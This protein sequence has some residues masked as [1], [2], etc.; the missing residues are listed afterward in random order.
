MEQSAWKLIDVVN[1]PLP[2]HGIVV[3]MLKILNLKIAQSARKMKLIIAL[4][5]ILRD[6]IFQNS[7]AEVSVK[8]G[9]RP[10]T[11]AYSRLQPPTAVYS[12]LQ[13][14]TAAYSRLQPPTGPLI[15]ICL[16]LDQALVFGFKLRS[17]PPGVND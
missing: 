16:A 2:L 12:R 14:S 15:S 11:A 8:G 7:V 5:F 6:C 17:T 13:Q 10:S 4:N 1:C 3:Y 9:Y